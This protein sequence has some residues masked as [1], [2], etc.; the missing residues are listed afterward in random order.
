MSVVFT[1]VKDLTQRVHV[2]EHAHDVF[3]AKIMLVCKVY[4]NKILLEQRGLGKT[5]NPASMCFPFW[6]TPTELSLNQLRRQR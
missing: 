6:E 1:C 4:I 3:T 5:S 2:S